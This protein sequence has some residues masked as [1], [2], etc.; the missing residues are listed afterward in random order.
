V[1]NIPASMLKELPKLCALI[2]GDVVSSPGLV[3]PQ[4]LEIC[5][6][7]AGVTV[8][9]EEQASSGGQKILQRVGHEIINALKARAIGSERGFKH[10]S[11][12]REL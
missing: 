8:M 5:V 1:K 2:F 7:F 3:R 10:R 4:H 12:L 11:F 6:H 9:H